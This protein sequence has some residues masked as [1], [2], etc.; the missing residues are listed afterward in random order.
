MSS[1]SGWAA[2]KVHRP[3]PGVIDDTNYFRLEALRAEMVKYPEWDPPEAPSRDHPDR[4]EVTP[5]FHAWHEATA[6]YEGQFLTDHPELVQFYNQELAGEP[7]DRGQR[8]RWKLIGQ[9]R[10]RSGLQR[11]LFVDPKSADWV[12]D[13]VPFWL[14]RANRRATSPPTS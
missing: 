6:T 11:P 3:V 10:T 13:L 7:Y 14:D 5:R 12:N 8:E 1:R 4:A 2:L 9:Y